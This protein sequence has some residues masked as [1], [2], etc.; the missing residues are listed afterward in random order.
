MPIVYKIQTRSQN[1]Y[2]GSGGANLFGR[3]FSDFNS[4]QP[5]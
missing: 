3:N 4:A 1:F 2:G 5:I